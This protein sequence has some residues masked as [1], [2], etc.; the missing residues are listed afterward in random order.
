MLNES[1]FSAASNSISTLNASRY[2]LTQKD[3]RNIYIPFSDLTNSNFSFSD[4]SGA[5][6]RYAKISHA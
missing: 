6:L 1:V 5:D 4:L 3:F 2:N